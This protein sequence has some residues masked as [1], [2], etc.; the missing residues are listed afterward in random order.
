MEEGEHQSTNS[1]K[2]TKDAGITIII[3][4][5]KESITE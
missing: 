1:E 2:E 3:D 4:K 5:E